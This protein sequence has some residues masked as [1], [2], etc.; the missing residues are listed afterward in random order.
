[1]LNKHAYLF[2]YYILLHVHVFCFIIHYLH[3]IDT[4]QRINKVLEPIERFWSIQLKVTVNSRGMI[5]CF[6]TSF[7]EQE[8]NN[9]PLTYLNQG[10]SKYQR[11]TIIFSKSLNEQFIMDQ[12]KKIRL[13]QTSQFLWD[14]YF[15][16][17]C[18]NS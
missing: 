5:H 15:S 18:Q 13:S 14:K 3:P 2:Y 17:S 7:F 12:I 1:M 8:W 9:S 16:Y 10:L 4:Y 6:Q 11:V